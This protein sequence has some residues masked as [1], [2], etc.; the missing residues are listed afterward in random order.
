[1]RLSI[2]S[3]LCTQRPTQA[4]SRSLIKSA[5]WERA[6]FVAFLAS[7]EIKEAI[8]NADVRF[9]IVLPHKAITI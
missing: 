9:L 2:E 8:Q 6:G 4:E 1:M 7:G 3:S 5:H